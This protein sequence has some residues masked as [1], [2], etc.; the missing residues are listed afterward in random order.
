MKD[1]ADLCTCGDPRRR[2]RSD[3]RCTGV[4]EKRSDGFCA[5][6]GFVG[7][8]GRARPAFEPLYYPAQAVAKAHDEW[9]GWVQFM[10]D[11]GGKP[12]RTVAE[13]RAF[14]LD[15]FTRVEAERDAGRRDGGGCAFAGPG[16]GDCEHFIGLPG[17]SISGQHDGVD[18][19]VDYY[20]KPNGWCW[21][22]W[23]QEQLRRLRAERDVLARKLIEWREGDLMG[24][25][26]LIDLIFEAMDPH[27]T[28][29]EKQE[30]HDD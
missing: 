29:I 21:L 22:C 10:F 24:Y 8:D 18:D 27:I 13:S 11:N 20:G 1:P 28:R 16:R 6:T 9:I 30:A 15:R 26:A 19:T 17:R 12:T 14:V 7:Q 5:C 25:D 3:G 23:K 2:H 4:N